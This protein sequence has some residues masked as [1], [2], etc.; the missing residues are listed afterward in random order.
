LISRLTRPPKEY[1]VA[2]AN[3]FRYVYL[4]YVC[5]PRS[6]RQL[7]RLV[8][9]HSVARIVEIGISD[10]ARSAA[11]VE[12]AQRYANERK[13][14]HTALDEF[15]ARAHDQSPLSL[16]EAYRVL[17]ATG[18]SVRLVPGPPGRSLASTANA[19]QN[20]DLILIS[21]E[22]ADED[23]QGGWFYLPRMLHHNTVI[24]RE[25]RTVEGP[26]FEWLTHSQIAEWAGRSGSRRA[27]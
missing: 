22:V 19:H 6:V 9:R 26:S 10:V 21:A 27:A 23:L 25:R 3:W 1:V 20:T 2:A 5:K 17:H 12:V 16:K 15:E 11:L 14:F 24:L 4:A 18:A 13:V 8:R 7:Y